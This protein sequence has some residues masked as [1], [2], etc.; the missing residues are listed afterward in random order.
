MSEGIYNETYFSNDPT[1]KLEPGILYIVVL[2]N[3]N[4]N[5]RTCVKIG[6]TKGTSFR[7]AIKRSQGFTGYE[8]RIQK[9]IK[10]T[11]YEVWKLEKE[12]HEKWAHRKYTSD[13]KFGGHTELFELSTLP[14]I[15][16]DLSNI[17]NLS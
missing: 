17:K 4:T 16:K 3:R 11:I 2:I 9:L 14:E 15:L 13:T 6:I 12:L 5:L 10:G 8:I 7:N 1:R